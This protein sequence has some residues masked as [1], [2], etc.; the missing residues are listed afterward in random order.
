MRQQRQVSTEAVTSARDNCST[1]RAKV[2]VR[3]PQWREAVAQSLLA[4]VCLWLDHNAGSLGIEAGCVA[5]LFRRPFHIQHLVKS[6][7]RRT[8]AAAG[9][10]VHT[11]SSVCATA[12]RRSNGDECLRFELVTQT[13]TSAGPP[14]PSGG[15]NPWTP[16]SR[17]L[18]QIVFWGSAGPV[19]SGAM[20]RR[21]SHISRTSAAD[22][23]R[24]V[25]G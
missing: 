9:C 11:K 21:E 1:P 25:N 3:L 20:R 6:P 14:A 16:R 22:Y 24:G 19:D 17:R 13:N 7:Q 18:S 2:S 15:G 4:S 5:S 23:R 10:A 8:G 12:S